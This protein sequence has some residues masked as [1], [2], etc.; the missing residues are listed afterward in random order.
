MSVKQIAYGGIVVSPNRLRPVD[1]QKVDELAESMAAIGQLQPLLVKPTD[2]GY[3]Y[4]LIFGLHRFEAGRKLNWPSIR[5]EIRYGLDAD[6]ALLAQIDENLIRAELGPAVRIAHH[7][8]RKAIYLRLHPETGKGKAPGKAG[9][10]KKPREESQAE[11]LRPSYLD[12][13]AKKT[14]RSRATVARDLARG[15][16]IEAIEELAGTSLDKNDELDAMASL[17]PDVQKELAA[18][19]KKGEKVSAKATAKKVKRAENEI[20]TAE[21][22]AAASKEIGHK[23]YGVIYADPPWRFEPYSRETGMDR[24]ADNHY[25]TM[26]VDEL[27]TLA[28]KI[29]A[30]KDCVLFLW[31]TN[32]FL[33]IGG[34]IMRAWGFEYKTNFVWG[35]DKIGHGYWNREKHEILL[36]GTRG[37]IPAP[38]PGEQYES[39]IQAKR[40]DHSRKPHHFREIIEDMFP[41]MTRLEMFA[42][43]EM[44]GWDS[45]GNEVG[46]K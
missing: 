27:R 41:S 11:T 9:G 22:T 5:C 14:G 45:W 37:H 17:P 7:R 44:A 40:L 20:K 3:R 32:P 23:L 30:A 28:P 38:A 36:I 24:A 35:K 10:G 42:R 15:A 43:E 31:V 21:R 13:A 29:P 1:P 4:E 2:D 33:M 6:H 8:E 39:L 18:K 16:K 26:T 19:A 34:E 12:D 25:P 46:A